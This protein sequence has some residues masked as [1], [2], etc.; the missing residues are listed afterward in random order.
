MEPILNDDFRDMLCLFNEEKVEYLLVG[1]WA[2]SFHANFRVTDDIDLWVK[3]SPDNAQRVIRALLKF[4][5]PLHGMDIE[6]FAKPRYG[7]H[8]G[9]PPGRIDL[10]TTLKG[11]SFEQAWANR[12]SDDLSGIPVQVIG[13]DELLR[14]KSIVARPKDLADIDSIQQSERRRAERQDTDRSQG[15]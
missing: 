1:G 5:A 14:N 10:M 13:R 7:L 12:V 8:I 6:E 11:V 2:V 4:G 3:P 15:D 9:V